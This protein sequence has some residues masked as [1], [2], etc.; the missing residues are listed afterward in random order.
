MESEYKPNKQINVGPVERGISVVSGLSL[1]VLAMLRPN[2]LSLPLALSGAYMLFRGSTGQCVAYRVL[3]IDR[4]N[5]ASKGAMVIERAM[6]IRRPRSEV[7]AF[8]RDFENL[9]RFMHHLKSVSVNKEDP[10]LSHWIAKAPLDKSVKWDA[11][12]IVEK[13]NEMI[14]WRSLPNLIIENSGT[15][16]FKDAPGD[17]GT[18]VHI[19]MSYDI[20]GGSAA[21]A[22]AKLLGEEPGRQIREDLRRFKQI[23]ETGQTATVIGQPSGRIEQTMKQRDEISQGKVKDVVQEASEESFPASDPPGWA[24]SGEE[25]T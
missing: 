2:K 18:E 5:G 9:P 25:T 12:I 7:F 22:L 23:L 3:E 15:V 16:L 21:A 10:H 1:V 13:E 4:A 24:A 20:L 8:W 14:K 6:T 17:R 19:T 11:E